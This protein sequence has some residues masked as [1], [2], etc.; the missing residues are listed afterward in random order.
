MIEYQDRQ[1]KYVVSGQR[2]YDA[3][4]LDWR[5]PLWD[6][7]YIQFWRRA[8][9]SLKRGQGLYRRVLEKDN[10]GGVWQNI[11]VNAKTIRPR[12]LIPLRL[13][14]KALHAPM[15]RQAWHRFERRAFSWWM[16]P[17]RLSAVVPYRRALASRDD[18]RH[19][20]AWIT[21]R[22]LGQHGVTIAGAGGAK[23]SRA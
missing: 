12:W 23:P 18:A 20:L 8:E 14:A 9:A 6:D 11:P 15:G 21:D 3:L 19:A 2:T 1:A 16:D 4:G 17:L 10:W 7:E 22:Y 5:L 13:T